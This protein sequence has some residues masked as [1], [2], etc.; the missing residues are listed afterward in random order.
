MAVVQ[1]SP[2]RPDPSIMSRAATLLHRG[3][4]V[5]FPT[6]TVYGLGADALDPEAVE[7]IYEAKG[8]PAY[9]PL[10]VHVPDAA[11]AQSLIT[12]WPPAADALAKR[13]WPGPLTL[14]LPKAATVP[15]TA[16]AGLAT[17][18]LRAPAHPVA[19]AL[20]RAAGL[21]LAAPSANRSGE[22]SP[23]TASH[24]VQSLGDRVPLI[25]DAGPTS[26]GIESTVVDLSG[27]RP[28]LLRPGMISREMLEEVIGPV[29]VARA[30][31]LAESARPSPGMLDRHYAPKA[32]VILFDGPDEA[33]VQ[34]ALRT[35]PAGTGILHWR[36]GTFPGAFVERL[37][38]DPAGYARSLYEA[39]RRMDDRGASVILVERPPAGSAWEA[40]HDRLQRAA[41]P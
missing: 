21:P 14:V 28:L 32:R 29:D 24:V 39:L 13:W 12:S 11:A 25:L 36:D 17:V 8:R 23:T 15:S 37:P 27:A 20:L 16:T 22:V 19:Q 3:Q 31:D 7:R 5:A 34:E 18:A 6:E 35:H 33:P 40:L 10:I 41:R 30:L 2:E 9:N 38:A 1:V 26:V 4:I